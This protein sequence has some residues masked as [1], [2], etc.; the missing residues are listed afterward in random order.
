MLWCNLTSNTLDGQLGTQKLELDANA[1][2][3]LSAPTTK[4]E[5]YN[6]KI[7]FHLPGNTLLQPLC[8]T[9]WRHNPQARGVFFVVQKEGERSPRVMGLSDYRDPGKRAGKR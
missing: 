9:T 8:E 2:K 7:S 5:D 1:R 4:N 3:V 6:V